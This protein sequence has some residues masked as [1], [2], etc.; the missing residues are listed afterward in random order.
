MSSS[1]FLFVKKGMRILHVVPN[2]KIGG[3]QRLVLDICNELNKRKYITTKLI[4]F[5]NINE[6]EYLS[7]KIEII[8]CPIEVNLS[9]IKKNHVNISSYE[10]IVSKF[11]PDIIHS[12]LYLSEIVVHENLRPGIKYVSHCHDNIIQFKKLN[13]FTFLNKKRITDYYERLRLFSKYND[14][15]TF[16]AISKDTEKYFKSNLGRNLKSNVLLIHN[17]VD[18]NRFKRLKKKSKNNKIIISNIGNLLEKKNQSFLIDI[19]KELKND[20]I[21]FKINIIGD[22]EKREKLESKIRHL[23]LESEVKILGAKKNIEELLWESDL[24]VHTAIYE[25]YGLVILEAMAAEVPVICLNGKGNKDI[26]ENGIN[27]FII[28]RQDAITFKEKI[29]DLINND[30]LQKKFI[31][32]G[33]KIIKEN[34]IKNY[35]KELFKIYKSC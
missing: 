5:E 13:F 16:I 17:S 2:L 21:D 18:S 1:V 28:D 24:Y 20:N 19:A 30:F 27:G 3:A 14:K 32:N 9:V 4:L 8:H 33:L 31:E 15:K 26:I 6:F 29:L 7:N 35:T 34:D 22:G 10:R 25:P 11:K 23:N 12:H